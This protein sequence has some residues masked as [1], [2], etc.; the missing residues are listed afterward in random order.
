MYHAPKGKNKKTT[1]RLKKSEIV[2]PPAASSEHDGSKANDESDPPPP[3]SPPKKKSSKKK[4]DLKG[5]RIQEPVDA[6]APRET[7]DMNNLVTD[8]PLATAAPVCTRRTKPSSASKGK[9]V[10]VQE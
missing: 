10:V 1:K 2:S 9:K 3:P 7:I 4:P 6:P 8:P 5:V